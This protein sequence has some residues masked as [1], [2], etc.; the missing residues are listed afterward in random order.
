MNFSCV[1]CTF[2]E[3]SVHLLVCSETSIKCPCVRWTFV[4]FREHSMRPRDFLSVNFRQLS[5]YRRTFRRLPSTL[6]ASTGP[7]VYFPCIHG[8]FRQFPSTLCA[9]SGPSVNILQPSVH[10]QELLPI[11]V[12]FPCVLGTVSQFPTTFC[13]SMVPSVKFREICV[14]LR[15]RSSTSVK[16]HAP[17]GPSVKFCELPMRLRVHPLPSII[18]PCVRGTFC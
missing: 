14:C 9:S 2:R 3:L 5:V 10:L 1:R 17:D 16:F 4:K 13:D 8:I 7:S 12:N 6:R 15:V 18:Y 11:F